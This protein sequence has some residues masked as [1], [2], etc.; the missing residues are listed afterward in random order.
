M[1]GPMWG[2]ENE[3]AVTMEGKE[4]GS[5]KREPGDGYTEAVGW[6]EL[7]VRGN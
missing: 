7:N 2:L 3:E 5:I 6:K 4:E 1:W